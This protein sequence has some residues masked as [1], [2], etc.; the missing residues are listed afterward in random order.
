LTGVRIGI[1][2]QEISGLVVALVISFLA[3]WRLSLVI[4]SFLPL[5]AV[6]EEFQAKKNGS[7]GESKDKGSFTEQGGQV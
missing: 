6:V 2:C 3:S 7:A 1:L 5:M 4:V